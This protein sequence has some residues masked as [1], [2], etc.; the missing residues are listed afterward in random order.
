MKAHKNIIAIMIMLWGMPI[1]RGVEAIYYDPQLLADETVWQ[2]H[3]YF[4]NGVNV[5]NG[6]ASVVTF[7]TNGV[8]DGRINFNTSGGTASGSRI[9]LEND[10]ILGSTATLTSPGSAATIES[11]N[12]SLTLTGSLVLNNKLYVVG[13]LTING[14]GN[15][16]ELTDSVGGFYLLYENSMSSTLR[17]KNM[18]LVVNAAGAPIQSHFVN[19]VANYGTLELENVSIFI[20]NG[21]CRLST[22]YLLMRGIVNVY[23]AKQ[24]FDLYQLQTPSQLQSGSVLHIGPDVI[25]SVRRLSSHPP[26]FFKCADATS[27]IWMDNSTL[28][29]ISPGWQLTNGSLL[30]DG[31][32]TLE[33]FTDSAD[34]NE[35]N[36]VSAS[37]EIGND[38]VNEAKVTLLPGAQVEVKGYFYHNPL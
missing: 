26:Q 8:L 16:L 15:T 24:T 20:Q 33:N 2:G 34:Y 18:N 19:S 29:V 30:L 25:F 22:V 35:N 32:V 14:G 38:G 31:K 10:L 1:L 5:G 6:E 12:A 21:L 36:D 23:G 3:L 13:D 9:V 28:R 11:H 27:T 17:L 37:F 4:K 7:H